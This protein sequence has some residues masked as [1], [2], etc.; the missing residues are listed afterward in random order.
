MEEDETVISLEG[1]VTKETLINTGEKTPINYNS[2]TFN[3][4]SI[5]EN[6]YS[7]LQTQ[8]GTKDRSNTNKLGTKGTTN[9]S[10]IKT[11]QHVYT[12][13][14]AKIIY[15]SLTEEIPQLRHQF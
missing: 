14:E 10:E 3:K 4:S 11:D 8:S 9:N 15:D 5:G 2:I 7:F 6:L 13:N 1:G 12:Y